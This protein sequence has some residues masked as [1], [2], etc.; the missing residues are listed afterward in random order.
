MQA[1][2][3]CKKHGRPFIAG[4][5]CAIV[6]FVV[7]NVVVEHT[8]TP[9][10]CGAT[11][12]EMNT[13]YRTWELSPHGANEYGF[14]VECVDCHLPPK[15]KFFVHLAAKSYAGLKDTGMHLL[16]GEYDVES[17]RKKVVENI[18]SE[19]CLHC[20]DALLTKPSSSAARTAH[21]A[22]LSGP[23]EPQNRCVACHEDV[24]HER[25][26]KLFSP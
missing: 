17:M 20:H 11:C 6:G 26:S 8:S 19:R 12:H 7:I 4:V 25:H 18:P 15:D 2:R 1:V 24:G 10:F 16:G 9:K 21:A 5:L 22:V 13:A 3:F 14:R 23:K